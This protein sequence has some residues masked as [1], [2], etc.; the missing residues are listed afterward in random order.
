LTPHAGEL[1]NRG[2]VAVRICSEKRMPA[3]GAVADVCGSVRLAAARASTRQPRLRA[4]ECWH[5]I[6]SAGGPNRGH[7]PFSERVYRNGAR[8]FS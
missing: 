6:L 5:V 7:T 4:G 8:F 2:K 1:K 3:V